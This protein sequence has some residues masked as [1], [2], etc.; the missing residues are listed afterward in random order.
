MLPLFLAFIGLT[1]ASAIAHASS[2]DTYSQWLSV[3]ETVCASQL[4]ETLSKTDTWK[5][6]RFSYAVE[7]AKATV[8]GRAGTGAFKV[9]VIGPLMDEEKETVANLIDYLKVFRAQRV[10]LVVVSGGSGATG[11]DIE[12]HLGRVAALGVPV[13]ALIGN[14][15]NRGTFNSGLR[16]AYLKNTNVLHGGFIRS[17]E[18][19]GLRLITL[20]GYHDEA[21][22]M[23]SGACKTRPNA[24][25]ELVPL[26][27]DS[28][29]PVLLLAQDTP[30]ST[31]S[32]GL[33]YVPGSG[34]VGD[35]DITRQMKKAGIAFGVFTTAPEAG[36]R[37]VDLKGGEVK[38][39]VASAELL[40]NPGAANS[41][42]TRINGAG[43]SYGM[44]A[45]LTFE[46]GKASW[47]RLSSPQRVGKSRVVRTR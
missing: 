29:V 17:I 8:K 46:D 18:F 15:E 35:S 14:T 10:D 39:K 22:L 33:D 36:G 43:T 28:E 9:G 31:G 27:A 21:R 12:R 37:A 5:H 16:D 30:L 34:N 41:L 47:E 6:G 1:L 24:P 13:V 2:A 4:D 11:R 45:V 42:P 25:K 44:A 26:A 38:Q 19:D 32:K 7:G 3:G 40:L 23:L 20:P